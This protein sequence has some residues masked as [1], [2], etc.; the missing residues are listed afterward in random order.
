M[1]HRT[2]K[3]QFVG[4]PYDG[5]RQAFTNPP[6]IE[7]LAL[8]VNENMLPLLKGKKLGPPS[9][10]S[11]VARYELRKVGGGW[12]YHFV[13]AVSGSLLDDYQ[14]GYPSVASLGIVQMN[15][16][17]RKAEVWQGSVVSRA[18]AFQGFGGR[19]NHAEKGRCTEPLHRPLAHCFHVELGRR[20][21]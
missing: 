4:G 9:S 17:S 15:G 21:H 16:W 2:V 11:T 19:L 14:N 18:S 10:T 1:K 13:K 20:V 8:P 6:I 5:R 7:R 12:Q 3:I